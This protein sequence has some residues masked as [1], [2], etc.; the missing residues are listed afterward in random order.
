MG[1]N[2]D[3]AF[4]PIPSNIKNI[5]QNGQILMDFKKFFGK[6]IFSKNRRKLTPQKYIHPSGIS[7]WRFVYSFDKPKVF[8][9]PGIFFFPK[10]G[11]FATC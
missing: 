9:L 1:Q 4:L 11:I 3:F 10:H 8:G 5:V 2:G 7:R 6:K